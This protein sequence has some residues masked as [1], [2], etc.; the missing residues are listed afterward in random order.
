MRDSVHDGC[1]ACQDV[2]IHYLG[3]LAPDI[4]FVKTAAEPFC[5][6]TPAAGRSSAARSGRADRDP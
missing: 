1:A 6:S 4:R 5:I 3:P 2:E